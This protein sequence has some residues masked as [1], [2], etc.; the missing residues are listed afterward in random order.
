MLPIDI[1]NLYISILYSFPIDVFYGMI[2]F[3]VML[4]KL[5][6]TIIML[7]TFSDWHKTIK[8]LEYF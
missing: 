4:S 1:Q 7:Y 5:S 3:F 2:K 8:T 6:I